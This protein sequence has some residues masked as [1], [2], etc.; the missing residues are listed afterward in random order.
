MSRWDDAVTQT[1]EEATRFWA[2]ASLDQLE[3]MMAPRPEWEAW[4]RVAAGV[5]TETGSVFEPGCGIGL[6][7]TVLP[8]GCTY[9]GVDVNRE[10][11]EE[12]KRAFG[13]PDMTF[14]VR[15]LYD[16]LDS[17]ARYDW[18]VV[19]SLFGMFPEAATYELIDRFW[20][21]ARLGLSVT[22]I[23]KRRYT[24]HR[25]LRFDFTAHDPDELGRHLEALPEVDRVE[26]HDGREYPEFRGRH[27]SRCLAA[28]AWRSG[29]GARSAGRPPPPS[30]GL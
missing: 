19:T 15:D 5:V 4:L 23:N 20:D 12:A 28:Y 16:V 22:T 27:W 8:P 14:E 29:A 7:T 6:L 18:V 2:A 26:L 13:G 25:L 24:S 9:F 10:F 1:E 3:Q 17:G 11:V 21:A 30:K